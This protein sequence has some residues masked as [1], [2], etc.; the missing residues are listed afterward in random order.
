[1]AVDFQLVYDLDLIET[2]DLRQSPQTLG[3]EAPVDEVIA[4][5]HLARRVNLNRRGVG[6]T[7][8]AVGLDAPAPVHRTLW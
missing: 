4:R 1:M 8:R 3:G 2:N 6:E 7:T 5:V